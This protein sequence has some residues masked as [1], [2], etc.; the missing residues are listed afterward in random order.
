V[1]VTITPWPTA[2][3]VQFTD[4]ALDVAAAVAAAREVARRHGKQTL[5]WW[6]APE[7]DRFA[8]ALEAQGLV[9]KDTPGFEAVEN[10]MALV[11]PPPGDPVPEVEVRLVGSLDE[12][13]EASDLLSD[14]FSGPRVPREELE[15]RYEEQQAQAN[16]RQVVAVVGARIVGTSFAA[17][18]DDGANLFGGSVHPDARGRG[19]YRAMV[20]A[21][22]ELAVEHGTPAL[23]VQAGRMSMPIL[24]RLGFRLVE[25]VR[26][27]VDDL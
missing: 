11:G 25:R 17:L 7:H 3:I 19:V 18:A 21:R 20:R 24:E 4:P 12:Y 16:A 27:F 5:G 26:I 8:P 6:V 13:C 14:V 1:L 23:T 10:C 15:R 2:Q 22:W 9:Q